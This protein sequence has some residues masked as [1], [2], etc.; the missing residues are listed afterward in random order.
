[1]LRHKAAAT[2]ERNHQV[3]QQSWSELDRA[4]QEWKATVRAE[5]QEAAQDCDFCDRPATWYHAHK[6]KAYSVERESFTCDEHADQWNR[7]QAPPPPLPP[8][9]DGLRR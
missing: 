2:D 8:T 1:L 3:S 5:A 9:L 7:K 4:W 6:G